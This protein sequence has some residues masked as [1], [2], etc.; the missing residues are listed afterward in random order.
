[1]LYSKLT[2]SVGWEIFT[3]ENICRC[4]V[5]EIICEIFADAATQR[6]C[7]HT[8]NVAMIIL[9]IIFCGM[10]SNCKYSE[11]FKSAKVSHPMVHETDNASV[12]LLLLS[13]LFSLYLS[14]V[15]PSPPPLLSSLSLPLLTLRFPDDSFYL[16]EDCWRLIRIGE[17]PLGF[18]EN[19]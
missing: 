11:N 14:F 12:I 19:T 16:N 9:Q 10:S 3:V 1:M 6:A 5:S 2:Y 17:G 13:F 7:A 18:G 4:T 8:C 15:P